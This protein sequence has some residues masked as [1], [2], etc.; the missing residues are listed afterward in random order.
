MLGFI[1]IAVMLGTASAQDIVGG[2][3]TDE[4]EA[5]G[6][7]AAEDRGAFTSFCSGTLIRERWVLTAA[8]CLP[9]V[10]ELAAAGQPAHFV[11]GGSVKPS[12][13][14]AASPVAAHFSHPQYSSAVS[15][16]GLVRLADDIVEVE[17][18]P[19]NDDPFQE[20][21]VGED[22]TLVG[23][24]TINDTGAGSGIKRMAHIPLHDRYGRLLVT[25]DPS[26][27]S[28]SCYGDSGGGALR[29]DQH[30]GE[31]EV[32]GVN[33]VIFLIDGSG[34][35]SCD[36]PLQASGATEVSSHLRW[37]ETTI[38]TEDVVPEPE[39]DA[40]TDDDAFEDS[41]L[42]ESETF[43]PLNTSVPDQLE[44]EGCAYLPAA[45]RWWMGAIGLALVGW[46]RR[47][48]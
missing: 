22:L 26:G 41:G 5:V 46:R 25:Y 29:V 6:S 12:A 2:T 24:G 43:G 17:P 15:D 30:T 21:W 38:E 34:E 36:S 8:H 20:D 4:F 42:T 3:E 11:V 33:A 44:A 18:L 32:V 10:A 23:Y 7:L 28:S 9:M 27:A 14:V 48:C 1:G 19:L 35:P 39:G 13:I 31:L 40:E 16:I 45:A 37:I 47:R